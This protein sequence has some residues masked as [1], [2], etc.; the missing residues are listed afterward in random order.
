MTAL[1]FPS[2]PSNGD[3]YEDYVY[4]STLGVWQ[5]N[6]EFDRTNFTVSPTQPSEPENGD[7][8]LDSTTGFTYAYYVDADSSQWIE[9]GRTLVGPQGPPG[10]AGA[11][12]T[13]GEIIQITRSSTTSNAIGAGSKTF[14]Y[15]S[16]TMGWVVGTRLRASNTS[17]NW[18]E[19]LV[20][21]VSSTSV[22]ISVDLTS[23]SGTYTSWNIS[24]SGERGIT[25][26][27][28]AAYSFNNQLT[29]YTLVA[30]ID[31]GRIVE[32]SSGSAMTLLVPLDSSQNFP[33]GTNVTILQ[34]NTGQVTLTPESGV[35]L[36][37]TPGLKLRT[38]WS[39]ATLIKR[40]ANTWVAI[41][42]LVP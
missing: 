22:T 41:G 13:A 28:S 27:F 24:V 2:S 33:I 7:V 9:F 25:G 30:A 17:T 36:N 39:S 8:W 21:S 35:T 5:R 3:T 12:G 15:T 4:D 19:G 20:T 11:T 10:P 40:A 16:A 38:Q 23:G 6:A 14:S 32:M 18:L 29:S 42:D 1:N 37:G 31:P 34:T 26:D